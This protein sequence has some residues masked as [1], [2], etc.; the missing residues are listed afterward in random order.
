MSCF[1]GTTGLCCKDRDHLFNYEL[2]SQFFKFMRD[3]VE[4]IEKY[5]WIRS[6]EEGRDMGEEACEEW[7]HRYAE[8]YRKEWEDKNGKI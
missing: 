7:V 1:Q 6:E 2:N 5:K 3:E 4:E 8:K